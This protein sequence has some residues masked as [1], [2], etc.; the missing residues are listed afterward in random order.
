MSKIWIKLYFIYIFVKCVYNKCLWILV[1]IR[2]PYELNLNIC[3]LLFIEIPQWKYALCLSGLSLCNYQCAMCSLCI[4]AIMYIDIMQNKHLSIY[5]F[6]LNRRQI[7]LKFYSPCWNKII[8]G[9]GQGPAKGPPKNKV[10]VFRRQYAA[11]HIVFFFSCNWQI[12]FYFLN[13]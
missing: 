11:P 2:F 8:V 12:D 1:V 10:N 4:R 9:G 6:N 7:Y 5:L 3:F 13:K